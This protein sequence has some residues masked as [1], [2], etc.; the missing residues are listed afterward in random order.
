MTSRPGVWT[1]YSPMGAPV[2]VSDSF[3]RAWLLRA[4]LRQDA[5]K[6]SWRPTNRAGMELG[7]L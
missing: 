1:K 6:A 2:L 4:V 7:V 5:R 3:V